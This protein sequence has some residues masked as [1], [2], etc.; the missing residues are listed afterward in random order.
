MTKL[1]IRVTKEILERSKNCGG[2]GYLDLPTN[3]NCAIALAIRDIFPTA[4]VEEQGI[5]LEREF[6]L[7]RLINGDFDIKLPKSAT[8]FICTFDFNNADERVNMP[9]MEFEIEIH[10]SI[11]EK[12]NIEELKPLLE[13]HPTLSLIEN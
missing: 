8:N 1:K 7:G 6:E 10:E 2:S 13:N 12:I 11:I 3:Q 4:V 9:E 5:F